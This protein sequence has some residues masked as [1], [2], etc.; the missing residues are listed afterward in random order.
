[1]QIKLVVVVV[2]VV[3]KKREGGGGGGRKGEN[4]IEA[5]VAQAQYVS[6]IVSTYHC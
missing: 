6:F 3:V 4:Y 1:M 5:Q 2:V